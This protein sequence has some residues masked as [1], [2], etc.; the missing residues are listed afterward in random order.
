MLPV[1]V[2]KLVVSLAALCLFHA[3]TCVQEVVDRADWLAGVV[4]VVYVAIMVWAVLRGL[5][6]QYLCGRLR[7][8]YDVT[9][10]SI[11]MMQRIVDGKDT[12]DNKKYLRIVR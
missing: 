8:Q 9:T 2:C 3:G 4:L 7:G 11:E 1:R 10:R 5:Q 12:I 6:H